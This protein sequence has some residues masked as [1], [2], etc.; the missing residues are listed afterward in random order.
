MTDFIKYIS[1]RAT[2]QLAH[3]F[4][5]SVSQAAFF[6]AVTYTITLR[7]KGPITLNVILDLLVVWTV[8]SRY[9]FQSP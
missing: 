6:N 5:L 7:N 9:H 8:H 1:N 2:Y 4:A 3:R